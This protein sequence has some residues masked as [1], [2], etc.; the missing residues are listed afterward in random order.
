MTDLAKLFL[1]PT[2]QKH[3]NYEV[4]RAAFVEELPLRTI[5]ERFGYSYGTVR[6]LCSKFRQ[7]PDM[8]FFAPVQSGTKP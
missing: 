8:C 6:N 4:L 5:A 7:N 1:E 3:K 2:T